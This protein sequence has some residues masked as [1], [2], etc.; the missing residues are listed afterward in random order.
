MEYG[1]RGPMST[2]CDDQAACLALGLCQARPCGSDPVWFVL[3]P[4]CDMGEE[5]RNFLFEN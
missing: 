3:W 5:K 1:T 2:S 4:R